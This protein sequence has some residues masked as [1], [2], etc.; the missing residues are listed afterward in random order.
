VLAAGGAAA[1]VSG[2]TAEGYLSGNGLLSATVLGRKA[3][4]QAAFLLAG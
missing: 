4:E 2:S 1:G 3:G